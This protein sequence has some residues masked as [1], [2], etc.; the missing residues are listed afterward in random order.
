MQPGLLLYYSSTRGLPVVILSN[1]RMWRVVAL[2]DT[3][4]QR[5]QFEAWILLPVRLFVERLAYI[6]YRVHRCVN[7]RY[8]Y[9]C[10]TKTDILGVLI[11]I[12]TT[13][14][15]TDVCDDDDAQTKRK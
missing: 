3:F 7:M 4:R 10:S 5:F 13:T 8:A 6:V 12:S 9:N 2:D 1:P 11:T 15:R 14:P